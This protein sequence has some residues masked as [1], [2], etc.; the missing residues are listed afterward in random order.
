M[1][2]VKK[3]L[4]EKYGYTN[5]ESLENKYG[6]TNYSFK[7]RVPYHFFKE[8]NS[9]IAKTFDQHGNKPPMFENVNEV[10]EET[11]NKEKNIFLTREPIA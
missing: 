3:N 4:L 6:K 11:V 2:N 1:G 7:K 9:T 10:D 5:I 8:N